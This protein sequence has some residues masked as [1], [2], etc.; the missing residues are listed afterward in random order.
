LRFVGRVR[1]PAEGEDGSW[2]VGRESHRYSGPLA[3]LEGVMAQP[4]PLAREARPALEVDG[5][6]WSR[7]RAPW[8][9]GAWTP[10]EVAG[11]L[12][13][14]RGDLL[15]ELRLLAGVRGVPDQVLEEIVDDA[16]CAVVMKPRAIK[17]E[18]HLR[19][20]F[21]LSMR[22]LL[23][24]YREGRHRVRVGSRERVDF[25]SAM[26]H[27]PASSRGAF[28][29]VE[30]KDRVARAADFMAQLD[31][32]EARVT[33]VMAI[34][35]VGIKLAARE[36]GVPVAEVKAAVHSAQG[37]L[38]QVAVIAAAGR[39]CGYRERSIEAHI[40]GR[41]RDDQLRAARAHLAA[42]RGCRRSYARMVREMRRREFQRRA[43]AAFLPV[44]MLATGAHF[45]WADRLG[46]FVS[47]RLPGA[48]NPVGGGPRDRVLALVGGGAGAAKATGI[49]AGAALVVGAATDVSDLTGS[50]HHA[51]RPAHHAVDVQQSRV[52]G[53]A[54]QPRS[55][56]SAT[57]QAT[58]AAGAA[59]PARAELSDRPSDGGFFYLGGN[60]PAA[61]A[62][63]V[64]SNPRDAHAA[65]LQ[66][67]GGSASAPSA[68]VASASTAS[69]P[70]S[71]VTERGGQFSP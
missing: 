47:T 33:A 37:K 58:V 11:A 48:G 24:R 14:R 56:A 64:D 31:D 46:A 6:A 10:E 30:L 8:R 7:L 22:M 53:P 43:S 16:I 57:Q 45:G 54:V 27:A 66:Y 67:L 12:R 25:D 29:A 39:M 36:L 51:Q 3:R 15:R 13:T 4:E 1:G 17:D 42:C 35:G 21:W 26:R 63:H 71:E 59:Q 50:H 55:V 61:D 60:K 44:P 34:E 2:P 19:R 41:A 68:T 52:S 5:G 38:E 70:G 62:S 32:F 28:E 49:L 20:A 18:E 23:A 9:R 40:S 69:E 65:S